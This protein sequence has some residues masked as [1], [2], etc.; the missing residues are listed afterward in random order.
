[1]NKAVTEGERLRLAPNFYSDKQKAFIIVSF[2]DF[3]CNK[4][5]YYVTVCNIRCSAEYFVKVI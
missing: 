1:M 5:R 4:A 3:N 2:N